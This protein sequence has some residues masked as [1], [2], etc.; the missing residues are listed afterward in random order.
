MELKKKKNSKIKVRQRH[1]S[2]LSR[3]VD[4]EIKA[5]SRFSGRED[6]AQRGRGKGTLGRMRGAGNLNRKPPN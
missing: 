2:L 6:E 1:E 3:V 4:R 5:D